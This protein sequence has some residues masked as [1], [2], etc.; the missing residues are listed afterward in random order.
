M[1]AQPTILAGCFD[2]TVWLRVIGKGTFQNSGGLK[3]FIK[4]MIGRGFRRFVVDLSRCE[5]MDSTFMGTLAGAALN[6]REL[7]AP[8]GLIV[9]GANPRNAALLANL[10]LDQLFAVCKEDDPNA[11]RCPAEDDAEKPASSG[12]ATRGEMLEAHQALVEAAPENASRFRDVL[13]LLAKE[14]ADCGTN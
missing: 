13:E 11:P 7:S 14:S 2:D 9:T 6:L 5:L 12:H 4:T 10:G 3:Q 8:N 1:T